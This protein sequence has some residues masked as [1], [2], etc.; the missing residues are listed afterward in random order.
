MPRSL[1]SLQP[2]T[3]GQWTLWCHSAK[4]IVVQSLSSVWLFGT[5]WTSLSFTISQ[6]LCKLMSIESVLPSYASS[7]V[8]PH[9]MP[10]PLSP[11]SPP[12][13]N[14]SQHQGLFQW[15]SSSHQVPKYWSFSFIIS[16]SN[17]YSGLISFRVDL[18]DLLAIQGTL[19]SLLQHHSLEAPILWHSAFFMVQLSHP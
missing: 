18:F 17:E 9:P 13:F 4:P 15:V 2:D 14:L 16:P 6:S 19:T 11:P 1:S 12:A 3:K 5:P 10:H 7:S 8:H